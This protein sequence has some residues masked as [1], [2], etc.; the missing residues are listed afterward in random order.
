M[1][2]VPKLKYKVNYDPQ[3]I[4]TRQRNMS[5]KKVSI[6]VMKRHEQIVGNAKNSVTYSKTP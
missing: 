6:S 5:I 1:K 4:T 2:G 3:H